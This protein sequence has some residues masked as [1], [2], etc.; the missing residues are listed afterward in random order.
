MSGVIDFVPPPVS[1]TITI[2]TTRAGYYGVWSIIGGT[3]TEHTATTAFTAG[4]SVSFTISSDDYADD[5]TLEIRHK[6]ESTDT[7]VGTSNVVYQET[8]ATTRFDAGDFTVP[9]P[10]EVTSVLSLIHI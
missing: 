6:Y 4:D 5:D 3:A 2:P 9:E 8:M 7:G 10:I 1:R